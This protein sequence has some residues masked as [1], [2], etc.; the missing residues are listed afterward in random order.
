MRYFTPSMLAAAFV[1]APLAWERPLADSGLIGYWKLAGDSHDYSGAGNHA[2]L[3][4]AGASTSSNVTR[5]YFEVP[6]SPSLRIGAGDFSISAWVHTDPE[7]SESFGDIVSKYDPDRRVGFNLSLA[8]D[9]S[10]YNSSSNLRHL[11]VDTDSGGAG[12]WTDCG[13]PGGKSHSS[14]ALTVFDGDLYAGTTD[15]PGVED[16]CHVYRYRGGADWEDCGRVGSGRTRG[17]YAMV[18]HDRSLYAATSASHGPQPSTMDFGRVYRYRGGKEWEDIGQPGTNYRLNSL[19]T[20]RGRLYVTG[21]NIGSTPGH[22]YVYDGGGHWSA[23]GEFDGWPHT[24]A[25]HDGKLYTAYPK[26]EVFAY[27]GAEWQTLGNPFGSIDECSQIHSL[28]TYRGEL[29]VGSWP[30]GRVARWHDGKWVD[31]GRP[32]DATEVIALAVHNGSLLAG[33]I[34]RAEVFRFDHGQWTSLRRL[35]DPPAFEPVPVGSKDWSRVSDWSRATS[36]AVYDGRLFVTTG[37]CHRTMIESPLD[38]EVRGKVYAFEVGSCVSLDRDLG[39]G[40]KHVTAVRASGRMKLYVDGLLAAHSDR[41][42][43][44]ITNDAP[45]R[46]GLGERS[47]FSGQIRDVRLYDR[48][49]DDDEVL[50]DFQK[51]RTRDSN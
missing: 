30:K 14:D 12:A 47:Y 35:F 46:I 41:A 45:L 26:G 37:T 51:G 43:L 3:G 15:G 13:R 21:F 36:I 49:I 38:D 9:G 40:W 27:D 39:A 50:G 19:A 17:V 28:G 29:H 23:C 10:G 31:C 42:K 34:P 32:G 4:T 20:Y 18:V 48:A 24:L 16:W 8:S 22:C 44:D 11:A 1:A 33:T 2:R 6:S 25:V 5:R 7:L